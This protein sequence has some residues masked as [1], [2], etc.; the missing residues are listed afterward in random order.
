[1][2]SLKCKLTQANDLPSQSR[3]WKNYS[4]HEMNEKLAVFNEMNV[5]YLN[6]NCNVQEMWNVIETW[7]INACD[8]AAPLIDLQIKVKQ[9]KKIAPIC[10]VKNCKEE[11]P[12]EETK[13][14]F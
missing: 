11:K 1:M 10:Q 9:Q 13:T 3:S 12:F 6:D 5:K 2:A 4:S 14:K 8:E 7:I